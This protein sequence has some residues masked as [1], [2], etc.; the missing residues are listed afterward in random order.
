MT[1]ETIAQMRAKME[2]IE[3]MRQFEAEEVRATGQ[4]W[5]DLLKEKI[6]N[7]E[8]GSMCAKAAG[9]TNR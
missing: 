8:S 3:R 7:F 5:L 2:L 1:D 4:Q 6:E 9:S